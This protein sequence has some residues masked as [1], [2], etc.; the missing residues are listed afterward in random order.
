MN[1]PKPKTKIDKQKSFIWGL[2]HDPGFG[3]YPP[4]REALRWLDEDI[5]KLSSSGAE[6]KLEYCRNIFAEGEKSIRLNEEKLWRHF[7]IASCVLAAVL[8]YA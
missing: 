1:T 8:A 4:Y 2:C 5:A 6:L 7:Q 3:K